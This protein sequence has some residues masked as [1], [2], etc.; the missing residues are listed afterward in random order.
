MD[1][2]IWLFLGIGLC[3]EA[4]KLKLWGFHRPGSGFMPFLSGAFLGL[5]GLIQIFSP[6]SNKLGENGGVKVKKIWEKG[7]LKT[8][9]LT[10]LIFLSWV[11]LLEPL[12]FFLTTFL[13]LFF[14]LEI[15]EPKR[16]VMAL[17]FSGVVTILGYLVF[18]AWLGCQFPKGIL[19]F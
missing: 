2:L 16:W 14:L 3:I 8:F 5:L 4:F 13:F 18:S 9:L 17:V 15:T 12:G 6:I 11:I 19:R 10:L 7:N 1:G